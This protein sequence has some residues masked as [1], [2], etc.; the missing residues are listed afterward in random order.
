MKA[1][2]Q[3]KFHC[4]LSIVNCQVTTLIIFALLLASC[5]NSGN[6]SDASGTFEATEVIVSSE[7]SGRILSLTTEEGSTLESGQAIGYIDSV[8]LSLRKKQ[9]LANI[10]AVESRRPEVSKQI[11]A[12]QQQIATQKTEKQRFEKLVKANAATQKQVDDINSGIAVLEKQLVAQQS[13]LSTSDRGL[14]EDATALRAQVEQ[15]NDQLAKCKIINPLKGTVLVKYAETDEMT[16]QGKALYK[17][18]DTEKMILRAYI[19]NGQLTQVKLGQ[20]VKVFVDY[21]EKSS[22][23]Y[24][25]KI[26]WIS[27]KAE[28]TPKTIQTK[29]ERA[30]LVYAVKIA[31][32]ND[33]LIKIGM[34][35]EVKFN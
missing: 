34:Y 4:Q 30:N 19:T 20:A 31:V 8:Q 32:K 35:G 33:G 14:I 25:G 13:S 18:A 28:F 27:N 7:A 2:L 3:P 9:L 11:A 6:K 5:G 24:A 12:I 21:G 16:T 17:I 23:E 10:K 26:E 29:D 1:K 22:K 15:L